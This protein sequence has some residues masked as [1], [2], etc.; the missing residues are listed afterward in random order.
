[1]KYDNSVR[2]CLIKSNQVIIIL[3]P[4]MHYQLKHNSLGMV[5]TIYL[6][7]LHLQSQISLQNNLPVQCWRPTDINQKGF[8]ISNLA[9]KYVKLLNL[10]AMSINR[11]PMQQQLNHITT[12][13]VQFIVINMSCD[14]KCPDQSQSLLVW[15][16]QKKK[17]FVLFAFDNT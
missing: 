13:S 8:R 3:G 9:S 15:C 4:Y 2:N 6:D 7:P 17:F 5:T 1:M 11:T 16:F 14:K 10:S 12:W